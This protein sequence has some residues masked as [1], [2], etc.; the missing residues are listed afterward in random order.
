MQQETNTEQQ[1]TKQEGF[2]WKNFK[3][4]DLLK[5]V[6]GFTDSMVSQSNAVDGSVKPHA[7]Y[8]T[9]MVGSL[10]GVVLSLLF[11]NNM[12]TSLG[13]GLGGGLM[14]NE[15][16]T[17][18]GN[19]WGGIKGDT[20]LLSSKFLTSV[21]PVV[22]G[23]LLT[24]GMDPSK[25][26]LVAIL[27]GAFGSKITNMVMGN[28][29][30]KRY[31]GEDAVSN[32]NQ[33][34]GVSEQTD[35]KKKLEQEKAISKGLAARPDISAEPREQTEKVNE[36]AEEEKKCREKMIKESNTPAHELKQDDVQ[37]NTT[38]LKIK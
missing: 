19:I 31:F 16:K 8:G 38:T 27:M 24:S 32:V 2:S 6:F 33:K 18:S 1:P 25:R 9:A 26:L 13:M 12:L 28:P 7:A 17:M 5:S 11:G 21:I 10:V 20:P 37:K 4:K 29:T 14:A 23:L 30:D 3:L 35:E 15:L 36:Q 34:I 22:A